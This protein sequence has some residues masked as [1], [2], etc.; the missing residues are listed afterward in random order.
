ME[1][2]ELLRN[3]K[4][5]LVEDDPWIM[6]SLVRFL[7]DK[8]CRVVAL[9]GVPSGVFVLDA[10]RFDVVICDHR[11]PRLDGLAYLALARRALPD[12]I[13]ILLTGDR[14]ETVRPEAERAGIDEV[15]G[16]PFTVETMERSIE[17]ALQR[18][19]GAGR[20]TPLS[21]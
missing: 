5:L 8:G 21:A 6:D 7:W 10:N 20:L 4:I 3:R 2:Y 13:L 1:L 19:D 18:F 9:G 14:E 16:K 17:R 11:P 15:I 12:A